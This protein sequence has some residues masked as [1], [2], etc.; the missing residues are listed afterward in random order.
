MHMGG[1]QIALDNQFH[2]VPVQGYM[3]KDLLLLMA[4]YDYTGQEN[5]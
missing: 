5:R 3:N 1:D 4:R 2:G